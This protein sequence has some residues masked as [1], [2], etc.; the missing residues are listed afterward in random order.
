[1]K[2]VEN[3]EEPACAAQVATEELNETAEID[4]AREPMRAK[5]E[6]AEEPREAA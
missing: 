5:V 4:A 3:A 2:A 6:D 1:M